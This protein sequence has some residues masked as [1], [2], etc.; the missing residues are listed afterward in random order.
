[1]SGDQVEKRLAELLAVRGK[2]GTDK[3]EQIEQ[4]EILVQFAKS[5]AQLMTILM[6]LVSAQF[7]A[8]PS[9]ATHMPANLWKGGLASLSSI[10]SVLNRNP[11]L[12]LAETEEVEKDATQEDGQVVVG[13]LLAYVER[14]DDEFIKGLQNIDDPHT[15]E[16]VQRLQDEQG[17]LD[18]TE[19]VQAYYA[20]LKDFK[21]SARAAFR[22]MEHVYYKNDREAAA[23]A[24]AAA[25]K[26]TPSTQPNGQPDQPHTDIHPN[27]IIIDSQPIA[28][29]TATDA[30]HAPAT[31]DTLPSP[32]ITNDTSP[33]PVVDATPSDVTPPSPATADAVSPSTSTGPSPH[34]QLIHDLAV[35]IYAHG[36]D[37]LRARAMLMH[38]FHH[39]LHDRFYEARDMMLMSHLQESIHQMDISTQI[40]FNRTMVQLGL[41]AFRSN[42]VW[43]AHSCLSEICGV[44][45]VKELLAQGVT[46]T[47]FQDKN[48]EQEKLEKKR[49]VPFHMHINLEL[50]EC[51]HLISAMLLEVPNMAANPFDA[52][53]KIISRKFRQLMDYF[54]RQVFT[55]PPE[56][57]RD[58]VAAAAQ[59]LAAGHAPPPLSFFG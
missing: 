34:A 50:L 28:N 27:G 55:G 36:D 43:E 44:S 18:L 17:F 7:D 53:R 30:T 33:S 37:R 3:Q 56:N 6:H 57:N 20:R 15:H 46:S 11:T 35:L 19:S 2:R 54:D 26:S 47:R 21:R 24:K 1:M 38:I 39:A 49:Q 22:R 45:R 48:V 25:T 9:V 41:C 31:T 14:L 42:L 51:V 40:L 12:V 8:S 59:A 5:D 29:G 10:M 4:L 32:V 58:F 13:N 52:K 16:Y 23:L